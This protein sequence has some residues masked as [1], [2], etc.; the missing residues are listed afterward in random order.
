[1]QHQAKQRAIATTALARFRTWL[2]LVL[3]LCIGALWPSAALSDPLTATVEVQKAVIGIGQTSDVTIKFSEPVTGMSLGKLAVTG[4]TVSNLDT[5]NNGTFTVMLTPAAGTTGP[6]NAVY[7]DMVGINGNSPGSA[8]AGTV[9]SNKF[10]LDDQRPTATIVM[11]DHSLADG[12]TS[13]VTFTFSEAVTGFDNGDVSVQNGTLSAV[14]S[15]DGGITWTGTFIPTA[16]ES[17][18]SNVIILNNAGVTDLV[19]NAGTGTTSSANYEIDTRR[20]TA[21]VVVTHSR[22]G[23][24]QTADVTI[25]FSEPVVDFNNAN[26]T[27]TNGTLWAVSSSGGNITWT[28]KFTPTNNIT[29]TSAITVDM[30]GVHDEAGN[31]G[32]GTA[33]AV[34]EIDTI[35]PTATVVVT[36]TS[37][38]AGD[39]SL[40][41]ITFSE[42]VTDFTNAD[43]T[44]DNGTLSA[45]SSADGGITWTTTLTPVSGI[46]QA[47]NLIILDMTGV[48]DLAGNAGRGIVSSNYYAVG[49]PTITLPASLPDGAAGQAYSQTLTV[50]GGTAPYTFSVTTGSLPTWLTL[51]GS[52]GALSGTPTSTGTFGFT[53]T[54]KD[55]QQFTASQAY[56]VTVTASTVVVDPVAPNAGGTVGS[57]YSQTFTFAGGT[58]PYTGYSATGLPSGLSITA[59]TA[60]SMTVS[61]TPSTAGS[62][63]IAVSATDS[64]AGSPT[65]AIK[66]YSLTVAALTPVAVS[67]RISVDAG[68]QVVVDLTEGATGGPFTAA[69]LVSASPVTAGP[70]SISGTE[71]TFAS[72]VT[73]EGTA[74]VVFTLSNAFASS[75]QTSIYF[76]VKGRPD[77]SKDS[78]VT[79]LLTAQA[80]SAR[81]FADTQTQN[82]NSRLEQLHD[83]GDRRR[84][85]MAVR[86]GYA[87]N[88]RKDEAE[89]RLE[90]LLGKNPA[91][92]AGGG[93]AMHNYASEDNKGSQP[94]QPAIDVDLGKLAIWTGGYVNFGKR[95]DGKLS[96]DYTT[97]GVSGGFDYRLSKSLVAGFGFG[98]GRDATDIGSNGTESRAHAY[99]GAVYASYSPL[100]A[101]FIDALIGGSWLDF[102]SARFETPTGNFAEGERDGR[103]IFGSVTASY[104]KRSEDWLVSPYGRLDF[105]RSWLDGFTETG[106]DAYLLKYGSQTVDT[107]SGIAG[108]RLEYAVATGWGVLKPGARVEYVHDFEGSSQVSLG[109]ADIDVLRYGYRTDSSGSDYVTL[110]ASLDASLNNH[111][112]ARFDYRTAVGGVGQSHAF[113]LKV[114]KNF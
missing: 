50:T 68:K 6:S 35:R 93:F 22:I 13:L 65:T 9:T 107:L 49:A 91:T 82:F 108:L 24:G 54:V 79:G 101:T 26:V 59:T 27:I 43:L 14:S 61:G 5:S 114:G 20:P 83:E 60:D 39:T 71:L 69:A 31:S 4:G 55:G 36:K 90:D 74:T 109:Y 103:Q 63:S 110:G 53:V 7:L 34:F 78:E 1:M 41:T 45:V 52:T 104:E 3:L 25:T 85:S 8:G 99:S 32:I 70:A 47:N 100:K 51:D 89:Q 37:L 95:D 29:A 87:G 75:A 97:V 88:D 58:A 111:W 80:D 77:P 72:D 21:T 16:D 15:S 28:A 18:L 30:T 92:E 40:V 46:S 73:F 2:G 67:R 17:K 113:G 62:F 81:R 105:S 112:T 66:T 57:A 98:Y 48:L 106:K 11:S 94:A 76:D 38:S 12:E 19:G 64:T 10:A 23:I 96:L 84:N 86:L 44:T 33:R 56:S 102:S 42:A